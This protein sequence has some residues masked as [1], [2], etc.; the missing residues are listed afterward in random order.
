MISKNRIEAAKCA[1]LPGVLQGMGIELVPNGKGYHFKEHDSLKLFQ[2]DGL[3]LYKWWSRGGEV[4]DGMQ[5]LQRHYGMSFP[6]AVEMLSGTMTS[7]NRSSQHVNRQN[8]NCP[9]SKKKPQT[10]KSKRWQ[11]ASERLIRVGQRFLLGP[12]GK[13]RLYY[14]IHHRGLRLD[15][16]RQRRLGWLQAKAHIPSKLLIPCYNSQGSLIRIR[17]RMDD[18]APGHERYRISKGSNPDSP[19]PI[20]VSSGKPLMILE[21]ELDAILIA[22][23]AGEHIGALGMGTTG[24]KYSPAMTRYLSYNFPI[25]LIS[26]DN[27]QSGKEKT[28]ALISALHNAIDWPVPEKYGKD[29]G[30]ACRRIALKQWV[31][32]GLKESSYCG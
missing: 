7:Q 9:E 3:W 21:S 22:Q 10:W 4:G 30:E 28:T 11:T 16:I 5:Y 15:T 27:D 23:E 14:L 12:N 1:D 8:P 32:D 19:Y 29:P 13:G 6:E 24:M 17:F 31:E 26:L 25:I 20:G 2:Q 18:P